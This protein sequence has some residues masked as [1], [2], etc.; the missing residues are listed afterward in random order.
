[1]LYA[2]RGIVS[3]HIYAITFRYLVIQMHSDNQLVSEFKFSS[4]FLCL[5][6]LYA[7]HTLYTIRADSPI[8]RE[9]GGGAAFKTAG[10]TK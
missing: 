5:N 1:M 10:S 2:H 4:W 9:G 6:Y 3:I 7:L 8:A